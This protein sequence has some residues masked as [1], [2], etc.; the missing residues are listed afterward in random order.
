MKR[1]RWLV[2]MHEAARIVRERE[3]PAKAMQQ[4]STETTTSTYGGLTCCIKRIY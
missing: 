2:A 3:M 1:N 4:Y